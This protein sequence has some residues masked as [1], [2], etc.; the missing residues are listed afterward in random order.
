MKHPD[1]YIIV[2]K[3][4]D[5]ALGHIK[6]GDPIALHWSPEGGGW[7]QWGS[8]AQAERFPSKDDDK[9]RGILEVAA[10]MGPWFYYPDPATI[11]VKAVP[12]IVKVEVY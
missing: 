1:R 2:A 6:A 8:V 11:E 3:V 4:K 5:D 7:W 9:F 12:A 10:K